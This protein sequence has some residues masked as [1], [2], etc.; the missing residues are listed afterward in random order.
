MEGGLYLACRTKVYYTDS[1]VDFNKKLKEYQGV[2]SEGL[3]RKLAKVKE[4]QPNVNLNPQPALDVP[5][6]KQVE[7]V[8]TL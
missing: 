8:P 2:K 4:I 1:M 6:P 3:R 5:P 7:E